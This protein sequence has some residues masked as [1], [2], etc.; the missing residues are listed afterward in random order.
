VY[1]VLELTRNKA[2]VIEFNKTTP[3]GYIQAI[4]HQA[5]MISTVNYRLVKVFS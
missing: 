5:L 2:S 1:L 3:N 4:A